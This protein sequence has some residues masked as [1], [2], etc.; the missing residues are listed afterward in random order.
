[1]T[2]LLALGC[3]VALSVTACGGS[4]DKTSTSTT[5]STAEPLAAGKV[6]KA[7][8]SNPNKEIPTRFQ[9]TVQLPYRNTV[10]YVTAIRASDPLPVRVTGHDK[11]AVGVVVGIRNIGRTPWSGAIGPL[12]RLAVSDKNRPGR[13]V[14]ATSSS[15]GPCPAAL[16]QSRAPAN[17]AAISVAPGRSV[18]ACVRF[19]L[20]KKE[21]PILYKFAA[22]NVDYTLLPL[23]PDAGHGYG[24]WALPGT[25]VEKCR[26]EP[27]QVKGHCHGLEVGEKD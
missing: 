19:L 17:N 9:R 2:R 18:F 25:L 22:R 1:M 15:A 27:S 12:S 20:P 23:S 4:G 26:F 24:V 16:V 10:L 11:R 5:T 7:A 14:A 13:I 6:A 8:R 21:H 3:A